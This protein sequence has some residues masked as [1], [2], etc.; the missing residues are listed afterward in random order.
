ML[1]VGLAAILLVGAM[2]A[3]RQKDVSIAGANSATTPSPASLVAVPPG[4]DDLTLGDPSSVDPADI[5]TRAKTR[6]LVWTHDAVLVSMRAQPV[7]G[8]K[9]NLTSGGTVE[10]LFGKPTGEGFGAGARVS[11]KRL[12][13]TLASSGSEV[14]EVVAGAPGR[15]ALEPNC[16]LDEAAR[17]AQAAGLPASA[18]VSVVYEFS[19]KRSK[20]IWRVTSSGG[21]SETRTLDGWTCAILVR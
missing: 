13:I 9:V 7:T 4:P 19:D 6:A 3:P 1:G 17:K 21:S 14:E 10:Y 11:G 5:L 2:L 12:R 16:P 18:P 20:P 8:G 15:A